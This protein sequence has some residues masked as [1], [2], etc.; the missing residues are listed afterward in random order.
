[1]SREAP[2][3]TNDY[4]D[5]DREWITEE[6]QIDELVMDAYMAYQAAFGKAAKTFVEAVNTITTR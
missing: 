3:P 4:A 6:V 2:S 1:M 5:D